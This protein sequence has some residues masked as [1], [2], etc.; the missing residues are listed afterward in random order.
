MNFKIETKNAPAGFFSY[1]KVTGVNE[2]VAGM[3]DHKRPGFHT[4]TSNNRGKWGRTE[5][6]SLDLLRNGIRL[7]VR[8]LEKAT[9]LRPSQIRRL[10]LLKAGLPLV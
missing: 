10:D 9:D 2:E 5:E 3:F 1:L 6:E 8:R 7:E 4:L